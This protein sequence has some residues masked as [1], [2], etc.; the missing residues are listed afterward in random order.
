MEE[1]HSG[2][3]T[4]T[5]DMFITPLAN[6]EKIVEPSKL[7]H[8]R[9]HPE[10]HKFDD[11]KIESCIDENPE[12]QQNNHENANDNDNNLPS[13]TNIQ[14]SIAETEYDEYDNATNA[15]KKILKMDLLRKLSELATQGV[16]VNNYDMDSDYHV[17][18]AE[19]DMHCAIRSKSN[20]V[21]LMQYFLNGGVRVLETLNHNYDPFHFKLD[22]WADSFNSNESSVKSAL[23]ELYDKRFSTSSAMPPE[24]TLLSLLSMSAMQVHIA[25]I[26]S[27][28]IQ[29]SRK[30][31]MQNLMQI[32]HAAMYN[33]QN[34]QNQ[35][36]SSELPHAIPQNVAVPNSDNSQQTIKPPTLPASIIG[37]LQTREITPEQFSK[38]R[39]DEITAQKERLDKE[40]MELLLEA[41]KQKRQPK[42]DD[43]IKLDNVSQHSVTLIS[44]N[45]DEI[46]KTA[47]TE[48][49]QPKKRGRKKKTID[50]DN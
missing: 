14:H 12:I 16:R 20:A 43:T 30:L 5:T 21:N 2:L 6:T 31:P 39:T 44:P 50:L 26:G 49:Q 25:N 1:D 36:P 40:K 27:S 17:M 47:E 28:M 33:Q 48:S 38:F 46:L 19:Y 11:E 41:E 4:T 13:N 9:E 29:D 3:Q 32:Q 45:L 42:N 37:N 15:R 22:G 35:P 7:Y 10:E 23:S 18:K 24:V 8:R 34:H